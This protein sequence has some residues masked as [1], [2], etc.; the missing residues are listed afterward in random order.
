MFKT[1]SLLILT[2]SLTT[3]SAGKLKLLSVAKIWSQA[4]HNAFT[5]L[6][7]FNGQWFCA[8][9]EGTGH[10]GKG[11]HGKIRVICSEDGVHWKSAVL[12]ESPGLD[13][14]DAKL[15]VMPD[16]RLLLNSCEYDVDHDHPDVRNNQSVT[17]TSTDGTRWEGPNR[18]A[19]KGY[20]L[21][22]TSWFEQKGYALG[23]QWGSLDR[24]RLYSTL[25]GVQYGTFLDDPRPPGDRSNEH[26]LVFKSDGT[27]HMLLRRDHPEHAASS[28]LL[29]T[30]MPPYSKW[31]WH[32]LGI[33]MGGPAMITLPDGR[34]LTAVRRYPDGTDGSWGSQWTELGFIQADTAVY[35]PALKLPSGGDSSYAGLVWRENM[36]WVS[37]YSSH[38]GKTSIYLAK[39]A[40][41][42]KNQQP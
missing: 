17:F 23:Y 12:L 34:L 29:G 41:A 24:T 27:L 9:R 15:S 39:V 6:E 33:K 4:P 25:D 31:S 28:A 7:H 20:W 40:I 13:L 32:P 1:I 42:K 26:A 22:Q 30:S 5:D 2:S 19:D 14:R 16:G 8:F 38:E 3:L 11:D 18:I 37:Y 21:W 35:T 36:L 10:A